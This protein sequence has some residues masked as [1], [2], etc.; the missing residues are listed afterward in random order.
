[1][2]KLAWLALP[3]SV[4][5]L[6]D[7]RADEQTP[8]TPDTPA[9]PATPAPAPRVLTTK[10][11]PLTKV[12]AATWD[13]TLGLVA[14]NQP[15]TGE[16]GDPSGSHDEPAAKPIPSIASTSLT[17]FGFR[18][19]GGADQRAG[20]E[21]LTPVAG[22][23][24]RYEARH[25]DSLLAPWAEGGFSSAFFDATPQNENDDEGAI[26]WDIWLRGGLDIHPMRER[27]I[28]V[29]PWFGYRQLHTRALETSAI[30]QGVDAGGQVHFRTNE[31]ATERPVFDAIAYGFVQGAGVANFENRTFL[32]ALL[33]AGGEVRAY[34]QLE[35][36][37]SSPDSCLP[38]QLRA[39]A[40]LGGV[41]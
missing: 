38:R 22:A 25:F 3:L 32:G 7:A 5:T 35:G 9:T 18:F 34:A 41:F 1:M 29:G 6:G 2:K 37:A 30:V 31:S 13:P 20:A 36:C 26:N 23:A 24:V 10:P 27:W 21:D 39:V 15:K 28:G 14:E 16:G 40:G 12:G 4:A 19:F 17:E 11:T 8:A 33:S